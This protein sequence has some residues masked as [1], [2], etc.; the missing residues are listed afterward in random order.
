M[1][2]EDPVPPQPGDDDPRVTDS[3]AADSRAADGSGADG[4]PDRVAGVPF[5][6]RA[7]RSFGVEVLV[8][9]PPV[10]QGE[11]VRREGVALW[12][13]TADHA[14]LFDRALGIEP[15]APVESQI[16]A[17]APDGRGPGSDDERRDSDGR[18]SG[19]GSDGGGSSSD[20][21]GRDLH[22]NRA[23]PGRPVAVRVVVATTPSRQRSLRVPV[24]GAR[25]QQARRAAETTPQDLPPRP[26]WLLLVDE[27]PGETWMYLGEEDDPADVLDG[28][29]GRRGR[30]DFE[31][32]R[33]RA[34]YG[35]IG[36]LGFLAGLVL[37]VYGPVMGLG[38]TGQLLGG[39]LLVGSVALLA[40]VRPRA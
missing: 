5:S 4:R 33:R 8:L 36:S 16:A 38:L 13:R 17:E 35:G 31:R 25:A 32:V 22:L 11:L 27:G 40:A 29:V 6:P 18:G 1:T 15:T 20:D 2:Q 23:A 3:R 28:F 21:E 30:T 14:P 12:Y 19:S 7:F 24:L 9:G 34:R 26:G 37:A 39:A 10:R